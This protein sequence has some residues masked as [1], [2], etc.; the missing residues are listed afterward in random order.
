ASEHAWWLV[1]ALGALVV[2]L[3]ATALTSGDGMPQGTRV[4]GEQL[5]RPGF[6]GGSPTTSTPATRA[7]GPG[8]TA[9]TAPKPSTGP[10]TTTT[11]RRPATPGRVP[12]TR[13]VV[14]GPSLPT[15]PP[16]TAPP[17]IGSAL[18]VTRLLDCSPG[19]VARQGG[20]IWSV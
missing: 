9:T 12:A 3:A 19:F 11:P 2:A 6:T 7:N 1:G 13:P 15:T 16:T 5:S 17:E 4:R 8:A 20:A 10:T 14:G 18:T